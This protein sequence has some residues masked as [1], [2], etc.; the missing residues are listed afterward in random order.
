MNFA[1]LQMPALLLTTGCCMPF[2][3]CLCW[4]NAIQ[5]GLTIFLVVKLMTLDKWF[6]FTVHHH[7]GMNL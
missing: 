1:Q 3:Y 6:M 2:D 5:L 4:H 7:N